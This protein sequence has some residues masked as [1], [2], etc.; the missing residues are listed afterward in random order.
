MPLVAARR[1]LNPG[2]SG[3]DLSRREVASTAC[4]YA[5]LLVDEQAA[6]ELGV[7]MARLVQHQVG[8]A[9]G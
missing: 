1:A 6:V 8:R 4:L 5:A 9:R 3:L 7:L 2:Q